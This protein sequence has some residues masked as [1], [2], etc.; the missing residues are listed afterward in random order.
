MLQCGEKDGRMGRVR[1]A[2]KVGT[3][4]QQRHI[5]RTGR[6]GDDARVMMMREGS[7][8]PKLDNC[9]QVKGSHTINWIFFFHFNSFNHTID[10]GVT[11]TKLH[12]FY[13]FSSVVQTEWRWHSGA[14]FHVTK[15]T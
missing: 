5:F 6:S 15:L 13:Y 9:L 12:Y 14:Y 1:Q 11:N 8:Q 7:A 3:A 10:A 4:E 2:L